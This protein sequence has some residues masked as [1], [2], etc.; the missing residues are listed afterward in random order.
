MTR[1][2][3][4]IS[5][6]CLQILP[7]PIFPTSVD[8][9]YSLIIN[10]SSHYLGHLWLFFSHL[11]LDLVNLWAFSKTDLE[12]NYLWTSL[13]HSDTSLF[14][15]CF[16]HNSQNNHFK[17][18]NSDHV[19]PLLIIFQYFPCS[20]LVKVLT[21]TYKILYDLALGYLLDY[22]SC[23]FPQCSLYTILPAVPQTH[24]ACPTAVISKMYNMPSK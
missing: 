5:Y 15:V 12:S 9:N 14:L 3:V 20:L 16:T 17:K 13:W 21:V 2:Q 10:C 19:T 22:F 11:S 18:N 7:P 24:Q 8:G 4:L 23:H 1:I 6:P